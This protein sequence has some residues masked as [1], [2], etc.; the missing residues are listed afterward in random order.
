MRAASRS[1]QLFDRRILRKLV[2]HRGDHLEV[3][4]FL[5]TINV[6]VIEF[7]NVNLTKSNV[8]AFEKQ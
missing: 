4:E 2:N 7:A 8:G 6:S 3:S 1:L 5:G